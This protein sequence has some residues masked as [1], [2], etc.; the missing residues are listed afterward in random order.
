MTV[1]ALEAATLSDIG[2]RVDADMADIEPHV[3]ADIW[4]TDRDCDGAALH[5]LDHTAST[6]RLQKY[7]MRVHDARAH[8]AELSFERN[9]F[10]LLKHK[11]DIDFQSR[12]DVTKRYFP[13][14]SKIVSDLTGAR[15]VI[16]FA[17]LIRSEVREEG[18]EPALS[19]HIDF[20]EDTIRRFVQIF[21]PQQAE[22]YLHKRLMAIN[23]WRPIVPVKR[24]P[25][26]L[27]D[28]LSV[29]HRDFLTI[30]LIGREAP[31]GKGNFAGLN[32][33]YN[34]SHRWFYYPDMQP[35]EVL[36]FKLY[37]S[38]DRTAGLTGHTAFDDPASPSDAV[39][40]ISHEV[41]TIAVLD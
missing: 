8:A 5:S 37:D 31:D 1:E 4:Y 3:D 14:V 33:A 40:R 29:D 36:A 35:D 24:L 28:A 26:A 11:T 20:C 13:Q 39:R 15:D 19:A 17:D 25:L 23:L 2:S 27:C 30:Y 18:C 41:R 34:P 21:R 6:F 38:G 10:T 9:G 22:Q 16:V 32:M 7:P 12:E